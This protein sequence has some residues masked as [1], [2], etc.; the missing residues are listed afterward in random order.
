MIYKP[1][2][3]SLAQH[4]LPDWF[5]DAKLGIFIYWGLPSVPAWAPLSGELTKVAE[6]IGWEALFVNNPYVEWYLNSLR[7]EGSPT[8]RHHMETYGPDFSYDDFIPMFNQAVQHWEPDAWASFFKDVGARY[9]VL[10]S[11]HHDGFLLWPSQ[12][13]HPRIPHYHASRDIVGELGEAVRRAGLRMGYYY[14][15]GLDWSFNPRPIRTRDEVYSTIVQSPEFVEY[16]DFHWREL[17]DRYGTAILWN[18]IGYPLQ[19]PVL[20]LFAYFYNKM[21]EGVIND[22]FGQVTSASGAPEEGTLESPGRIHYDFTTPEY[23][24]Y[25][26]IMPFKWESTRGIGFSFGY[27]QLEGPDSYMSAETCIRM[28]VDIVSKN[29]NLLLNVGPMPDGTIPALQRQCLEGL[30]AWLDVNGEAIYGTRPW[31]T[32]AGRTGG[33]VD[34]RY[35]QKG[36]ALHVILMDVPR[37]RPLALTGLRAAPDTKIQL[38]GH[39]H[40]PPLDWRQHDDYLIV[41]LPAD[42]PAASISALRL[43]PQPDRIV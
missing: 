17:I 43:T 36:D 24:S 12:R 18:D 21:P 10:V 11:K 2:I 42:L 6:E 13:P 39:E 5:N 32:F 1:T 27:N 37:E 7:I 15:G 20:D 41:S 25:D 3:D 19:A 31:V 34:V 30:G 14:S 16:V 22:R 9:V 40:E 23:A 4:P 8:W 29:G 28:F 35:T 33:G 26:R 38:L